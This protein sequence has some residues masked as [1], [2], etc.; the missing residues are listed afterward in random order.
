MLGSTVVQSL[1]IRDVYA[2]KKIRCIWGVV[3]SE[4][5]LNSPSPGRRLVTPSKLAVNFN[6]KR[7]ILEGVL[8]HTESS[9]H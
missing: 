7:T 4:L 6:A 3:Y 8:V 9:G 5:H 2:I 1:S